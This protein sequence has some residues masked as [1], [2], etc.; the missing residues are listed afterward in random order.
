[1]SS[2]ADGVDEDRPGEAPTPQLRKVRRRRTVQ[3]KA[4]RRQ[5]RRR[6]GLGAGLVVVVL[7]GL[8]AWLG[9]TAYQARGELETARAAAQ[10]ARTAL[11]DADVETADRKVD[12]AVEAAGQAR[13]HT[14]SLP[15]DVLAPLPLIGGPLD[16]TRR[17]AAAVDDLATKVLVPAAEAGAALSPAQLRPAGAQLD[18]AVLA[19]AREPL[20][21]ASA[22]AGRVAE[23]TAAIP[24]VGWPAQVDD[25]RL[26]LAG[27]ARELANLLRDTETAATLLP[28]MLG[29]DAP[30]SYFLGFQTN[31]EARGTG[32]LI[33][34]FAILQADNG[35]LGFDT[36][37][38]NTELKSY[39]T[40]ATVDL[41]DGFQQTWGADNPT[42]IWG[43]SNLSSDFP[44]TA[45]IWQAMWQRQSG[46]Q[47]DGVLATDPLAL[48]Y[49]LE[50]TGPVTLADGEQ[51]TSAN[52]VELTQVTAYARFPADQNA[53]RK[54]YLQEI[55]QAVIGQVTGGAGSTS[56][57]LRAL[58]RAAGEG[59]LAVWSADPGEEQVLATSPL[60][61][62]VPDDAAPYAGVVVNNYSNSKL[63]YYL[64]RD[65]R[66]TAQGCSGDLRSSTVTVTLTNDAPT[67]GLPSYVTNQR[68]DYPQG[69]P[70]TTAVTLQL[71]ATTGAAALG[72]TI[73]G[74]PTQITSTEERGHP[75]LTT[76]VQIPPGQNRTVVFTLQEPTSATGPARVPVQPLARPA[77]VAVD[78]PVCRGS[79]P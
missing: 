65:I 25:A 11:L 2:D 18:L 51:V 57:L 32:G 68:D 38:A 58:G 29:A 55:A 42:G 59:H 12:L 34:G 79:A 67:S 62:Q 64:G 8:A 22:A 60:G 69:P 71:L 13:D 14:S 26:E 45:K 76:V 61:R 10:D 35:A 19:G 50:A 1:M 75:S 40:P 4:R 73:D 3:R 39:T 70:G 54:A 44:S 52:V 16:T 47:V 15:W 21:R 72:V 9:I 37:A 5:L 49:I 56:G 41:P 33:G 23:E 53:E 31:A 78:V 6:I 74:V 36:V 20:Q 7:I 28:P 30:R 48:S 66:Y 17:I 43:N 46:Q 63:D 77:Q 24:A 27:Q